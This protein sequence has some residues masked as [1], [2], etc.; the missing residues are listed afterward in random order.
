[1]D[2]FVNRIKQTGLAVAESLTPVLKGSQFKE[3]GR[4]NPEEF[5]SLYLCIFLIF[6][7]NLIF[8]LGNCW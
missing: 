3:S 4:I 1:M 7:C 5:V 2:N 6:H 8:N